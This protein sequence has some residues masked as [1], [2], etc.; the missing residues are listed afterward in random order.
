MVL[1]FLPALA[2]NIPNTVIV[3]VILSD[4][5]DAA[6]VRVEMQY[7][8]NLFDLISFTVSTGQT[9]G[10]VWC[11][12]NGENLTPGGYGELRLRV[13][14]PA[15]TLESNIQ[16][17]VTESWTKDELNGT[18]SVNEVTVRTGSEQPEDEPEI[19]S[20]TKAVSGEVVSLPFVIEE[21][22]SAY[23][24]LVPEYDPNV[25][26]LVGMNSNSWNQGVS[27]INHVVA[28]TLKSGTVG[29]VTLKIKENALAGVYSV[30][31]IATEMWQENETAGNAVLSC[32]SIIISET[33]YTL[34]LPASLDE[35]GEEALA[36][37]SAEGIIVPDGV[38]CIGSR[39]FADCDMLITIELPA[40]ITSIADDAFS[41]DE[42][43]TIFTQGEGYVSEWATTH[44]VDC[45]LY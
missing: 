32:G 25:F 6:F 8:K 2:E 12:V 40:S 38:T 42:K 9:V 23:M 4:D 5:T 24:M 7:D 30:D 45:I 37:T 36:G 35:I 28:T 21:T 27:S 39:A 29:S 17:L 16:A 26:E 19:P 31:A 15:A 10:N 18:A 14:D 13:K 44:G 34:C 11:A 22:D 1:A 20:L 3:P 43:V 33:G 41:G